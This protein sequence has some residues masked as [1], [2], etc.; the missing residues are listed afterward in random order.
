M[1]FRLYQFKECSPQI[2]GQVE[3]QMSV[4]RAENPIKREVVEVKG[5]ERVNE[6]LSEQG[7]AGG[8]QR[9]CAT[10]ADLLRKLI[11]RY[12]SQML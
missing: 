6:S 2:N 11:H 4:V 8:N 12:F 3:N 5:G 7:V 10:L 1:S 9:F